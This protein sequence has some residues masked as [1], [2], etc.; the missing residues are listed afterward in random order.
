M[1]QSTVGGKSGNLNRAATH[2]NNRVILVVIKTADDPLEKKI[3]FLFLRNVL[4]LKTGFFNNRFQNLLTVLG[5]AQGVS[6]NHSEPANLI[7]FQNLL[8]AKQLF[9]RF[10]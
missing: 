5:P 1:K 10:F 9:D 8:T 3:G 4:C 7:I 2:I 6:G